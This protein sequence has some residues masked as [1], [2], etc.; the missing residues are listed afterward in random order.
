MTG[1][2][3][4]A[5]HSSGMPALRKPAKKG[6]QLARGPGRLEPLPSRDRL[7]TGDTRIATAE[8]LGFAECDRGAFRFAI[9]GIT[10]RKARTDIMESGVDA[11]RL[12][13]PRDR[14]VGARFKQ[15]HRTDLPI[16]SC[17]IAIVRAEANRVFHERDH[18]VHR[19]DRELAPTKP[20]ISVGEVAIE[21]D[22][23]LVFDSGRAV[24]VRVPKADRRHGNR[25][26][27]SESSIAI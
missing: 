6:A 20:G 11:P 24:A 25:A 26:R 16:P 21:G 5:V 10:C 27:Q 14:L 18:L 23:S 15:M 19:S 22:C 9:K 2:P 17:Q 13:E 12:L 7:R 8:P 4:R 1:A 3:S